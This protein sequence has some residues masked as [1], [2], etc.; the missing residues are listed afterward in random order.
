MTHDPTIVRFS[1]QETLGTRRD[2]ATREVLAGMDFVPL[3]DELCIDIETRLLPG[4]SVT[5]SRVSAHRMTSR[6]ASRDD[7]FTL[8][9]RSPACDALGCAWQ[10]GKEARAGG[11]VLLSN[12]DPVTCETPGAFE[13]VD[14]KLE[15]SVL[16]PL[17]PNVEAM[18][19]RIVPEQS[20]AL[21][22]LNSYIAGLRALGDYSAAGPR[23]AH[24]TAMHIADLVAL[25]IGSNRD[26][27]QVASERGLRA[28]RLDAIKRWALARLGS[29]NLTINAAAMAAGI[30]PRSVQLLFETEGTTF[31][32]YVLRERLALAYRRFSAPRLEKRTIAEVAY[33]CGFGDLSYFTQC[34]R[35]A[36]GC[37]PSEAQRRAGAS[38]TH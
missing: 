33:D 23:F 18:L 1:M 28:A 21:Q 30:S 6:S 24:M 12:A 27:T 10:F 17:L 20:E 29:P 26:A 38:A 19:M 5:D 11:A 9:W 7:T 34:F 35:A 16:T 2:G 13:H 31:T 22:L 25:A 32:K 8:L 3:S 4:V 14:V 37:T 36:Y 15:R